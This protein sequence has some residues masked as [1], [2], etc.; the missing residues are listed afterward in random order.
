ML[1]GSDSFDYDLFVPFLMI[2]SPSVSLPSETN[3]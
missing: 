1:L 3:H 2:N